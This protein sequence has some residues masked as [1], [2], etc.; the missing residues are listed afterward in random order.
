[1]DQKIV[2]YLSDVVTLA[3]F[4]NAA[5][6]RLVNYKEMQPYF[7]KLDN[8]LNAFWNLGVEANDSFAISNYAQ[9]LDN[10]VDIV[11][12]KYGVEGNAYKS[13]LDA[14]EV[15]LS[16]FYKSLV[17]RIALATYN[18]TLAA[19]SKDVLIEFEKLARN[20]V[21]VFNGH[22]PEVAEKALKQYFEA[23]TVSA[24]AEVVQQVEANTEI[25]SEE[26]GLNA[27]LNVKFSGGVCAIELVPSQGAPLKTDV[28]VKSST[29]VKDVEAEVANL[30]GYLVSGWVKLNSKSLTSEIEQYLAEKAKEAERINSFA[31]ELA[32]L[33]PEQAQEFAKVVMQ[34]ANWEIS[35]KP[36]E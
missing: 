6:M 29:S 10:L 19:P 22:T 5:Q 14:G 2:K 11:L 32:K 17:S 3:Q 28:A 8:S 33:T 20:L 1:M 23:G 30:V 25:A 9:H 36:K 31:Q 4:S 27:R 12:S 15:Y 7:E 26:Q 21:T 24:P 18:V 34:N 16:A 13:I 35:I